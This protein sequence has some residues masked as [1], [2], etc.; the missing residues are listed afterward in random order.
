MLIILLWSYIFFLIILFWFFVLFKLNFYN[1]IN[2][3]WNIKKVTKYVFLS[4]II[5]SIFSIIL[6]FYYN[7]SQEKIINETKTL[8]S[9]YY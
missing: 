4:L 6:I 7:L 3:D 1:F 9:V 8:E 2:I 5:T